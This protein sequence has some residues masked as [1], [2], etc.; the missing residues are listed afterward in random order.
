MRAIQPKIINQQYFHATAEEIDKIRKDYIEGK[1]SFAV[2]KKLA[3][4]KATID[5]LPSNY[6]SAFRFWVIIQYLCV[7]GAIIAFFVVHWIAGIGIFITAF[8]VNSANDKSA[9]QHAME[10]AKDD[11]VFLRFALMTGLF[12]IKNSELKNIS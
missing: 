6:R 8:V 7:L 4:S 12:E 9:A 3:T 5:A 10:V 2:S 1:I 11:I